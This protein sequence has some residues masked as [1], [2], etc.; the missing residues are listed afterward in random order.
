M[1][2]NY[3]AIIHFLTI[4][5]MGLISWVYIS[6]RNAMIKQ[7]EALEKIGAGHRTRIEKELKENSLKDE[8]DKKELKAEIATYYASK[9]DITRIETVLVRLEKDFEKMNSSAETSNELLRSILE[10][11]KKGH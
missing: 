11:Q 7:M 8:L 9:S 10:E 5:F 3:Q 6:N 1:E 4:G 2:E